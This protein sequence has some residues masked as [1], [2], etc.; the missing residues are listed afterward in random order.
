[1]TQVTDALRVFATD[2]QTVA[3]KLTDLAPP[4]D[5]K[6]AN[7]ALAKAFA[8]NARATRGVLTRLG[9]AK[10]PRQAFAVIGRAKDAQKSGQEID[11]ALKQLV[12]LGYTKGS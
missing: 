2:Q 7:S 8:D 10:T 11:S 5:A 1:V 12:K 3:G 4:S 9:S 6:A